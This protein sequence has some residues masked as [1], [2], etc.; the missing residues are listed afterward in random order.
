MYSQPEKMSPNLCEFAEEK[1][2]DHTFLLSGYIILNKLEPMLKKKK[3]KSQDS[4]FV[5]IKVHF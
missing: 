5:N 2:P 4:W 1:E 3:K